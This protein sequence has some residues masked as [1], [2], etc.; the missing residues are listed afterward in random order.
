[1]KIF[2]GLKNLIFL[3]GMAAHDPSSG[4][5]I[6]LQIIRI[7]GFIVC[8]VSML[9]FL[10]VEAGSFNDSTE[11]FYYAVAYLVLFCTYIDLMFGQKKLLQLIQLI[12]TSV[13]KSMRQSFK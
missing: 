12:E 1:M 4:K 13:S 3:F 8:S 9:W 10:M 11:A 5:Y 2:I 6:I 7:S